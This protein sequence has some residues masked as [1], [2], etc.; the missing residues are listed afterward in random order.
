M[1]F[2]SLSGGPVEPLAERMRAF[3]GVAAKFAPAATKF[4]H[5]ERYLVK[6][7]GRSPRRTASSATT[8]EATTK[9]SALCST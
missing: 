1:V 7:I 9:R 8:A 5:E 2:V 4:V 6:E 3:D